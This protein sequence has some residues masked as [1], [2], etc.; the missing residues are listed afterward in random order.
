MSWGYLE[1]ASG[2]KGHADRICIPKDE[3]ELLAELAEARGKQAPVT[4]ADSADQLRRR[5]R[6]TESQVFADSILRRAHRSD[7]SREASLRS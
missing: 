5:P 6:G 4:V 1:D 7:E 2:I 3:A